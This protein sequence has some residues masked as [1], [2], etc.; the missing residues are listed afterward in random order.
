MPLFDPFE[1]ARAAGVPRHRSARGLRTRVK[2][3][4]KAGEA[5]VTWRIGRSCEP[6][7]RNAAID[8]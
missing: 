7:C 8:V 6:C 1:H 2:A 5:F 3:A 4:S